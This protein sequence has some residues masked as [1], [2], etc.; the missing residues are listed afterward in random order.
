MFSCR[1]KIS[2]PYLHAQ[3]VGPLWIPPAN[4]VKYNVD[5]AVQQKNGSVGIGIVAH[6][7]LGQIVGVM[8]TSFPRL[9]SP[10]TVEAMAFREALVFAVNRDLSRFVVEGDSLEVVQALTQSGKSFTDCSSIRLD[11]LVLLSL[12]SS[13]SFVHVNYSCNRV[14]HSLA[15][16]SLLDIKLE[17]WGCP[18]SHWLANLALVDVWSFDRVL[19]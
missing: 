2:H 4:V 15:K 19:C 11:C 6:D 18:V 10:R 5:G 1:V 9:L 14:A 7:H 3:G 17:N 12:F 16:D 13:C 8:A